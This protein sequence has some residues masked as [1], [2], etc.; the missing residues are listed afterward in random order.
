MDV[1]I[2]TGASKGLG[3]AMAMQ[4]LSPQRQLICIARSANDTIAAAARERGAALDWYLQDL[5]DIDATDR[6]ATAIAVSMPRDA[7]RYTLINNAALMGPVGAVA[8]ID[9]AEVAA[10]MNVNVSAA[11]VLTA[12]FLEATDDLE[13]DRR[14]LN[15][16]SGSGR[17]PMDGNGVYSATK[18]ALDMFSRCMK[19]EQ[20]LR[21]MGKRAR[22]VSLA[23]GVIETDM[24]VYARS[25]DPALFPQTAFFVKMKEDGI[26]AA[27][28][29]AARKILGYLDRDTF[30]DVEID[31]IRSA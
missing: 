22:V 2:L 24:Q 27:P 13:A 29:D 12:R 28:E 1:V 18:A 5:A 17:R 15:I 23:P 19:A 25:R 11:I 21:P 6:L 14:V 10:T 8:K 7:T 31:D 30:G 9:A 4:L 26:L 3:A 20:D 16:S